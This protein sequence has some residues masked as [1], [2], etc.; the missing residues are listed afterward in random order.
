MAGRMIVDEGNGGYGG[1]GYSLVML[2][3]RTVIFPC[4]RNHFARIVILF[5]LNRK[6]NRIATETS[7]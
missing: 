2:R 4:S 6:L 5:R 1:R 3:M 7:C